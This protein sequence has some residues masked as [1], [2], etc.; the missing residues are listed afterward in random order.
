[1]AGGGLEGL[2]RIERRQPA[3]AILL[4]EKISGRV[5]KGCFAGNP[6]LVLLV[7]SVANAHNQRRP[8]RSNPMSVQILQES[9]LAGRSAGDAALP[10]IRMS[11]FSVCLD[12]VAT[13]IAR[14]DQ[15]RALRGLADEA[16]LLSDVGLHPATG[17]P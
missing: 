5:E 16:R 7:C 15:R 9:A 6:F 2:Q 3:Q 12:T 13:W 8:I 11:A 14:A 1:M 4:H 17:A 10:E